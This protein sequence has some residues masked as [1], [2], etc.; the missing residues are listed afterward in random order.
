MWAEYVLNVCFQ[1]GW[2][3]LLVANIPTCEKWLI[4][5]PSTKTEAIDPFPIIEDFGFDRVDYAQALY[6]DPTP[7]E[8]NPL[9]Q[10]LSTLRKE[11]DPSLILMTSQNSIA[12]HAFQGIPFLGIEQAAL[13]RLG[14]PVRAFFDPCGHQVDSILHK[15]SKEIRGFSLNKEKREEVLVLCKELK[16]KALVADERSGQ[17]IIELEKIKLNG[18]VALFVLQPI[19]WVTYEGAYRQ[20]DLESLLYSWAKSLPEGWIG[21]PTFHSGHRMSEEMKCVIAAS[22]PNIHF[23]LDEFSV[24]LSESLLLAADGMVTISSTSAMTGLLFQKPVVVLGK[25]PVSA[26]CSEDIGSISDSKLLSNDEVAATLCFLTNRISLSHDA[27]DI[28]LTELEM[29]IRNTVKLP[30]PENWFLDIS[31]WNIKAAR[32]LFS[33]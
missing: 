33:L 28:D 3:F 17:A 21:V 10:Q 4:K 20:I 16:R 12:K 5:H 22:I 9:F 27:L 24:G 7:L 15:Y 6:S 18:K 13:P 29:V 23:L 30:Q 32:S 8:G 19:D 26:W 14:H 31:G 2:E 1:A 11:Y 25:S